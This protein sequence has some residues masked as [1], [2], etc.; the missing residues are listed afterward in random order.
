MGVVRLLMWRGHD[1]G[2]IVYF[3]QQ[4]P[5]KGWFDF[6][7]RGIE[8][9]ACGRCAGVSRRLLDLV[10]AEICHNLPSQKLVQRPSV[11]IQSQ[12]Q[13]LLPAML[14]DVEV[15]EQKPFVRQL[16]T[17]PLFGASTSRLEKEQ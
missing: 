16:Y 10:Y 2:Q 6:A 17:M 12:Q 15:E 3:I 13:Q 5:I 11:K 4:L 8:H 9:E 7:C 1:S 14:P